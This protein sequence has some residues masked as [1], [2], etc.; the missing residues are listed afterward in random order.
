MWEKRNAFRIL[1]GKPGG[2]TPIGRRRCR[3]EDNTKSD[4]R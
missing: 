1:M 4:L 2:K 3:W